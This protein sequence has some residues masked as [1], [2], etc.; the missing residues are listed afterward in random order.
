MNNNGFNKKRFN[1]ITSKKNKI[2][3]LEEAEKDLQELNISQDIIKTLVDKHKVAEITK[4]TSDK[5]G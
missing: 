1:V 4:K 3:W 5:N 2:I